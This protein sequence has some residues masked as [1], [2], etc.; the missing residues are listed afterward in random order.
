MVVYTIILYLDLKII[1][2]KPEKFDDKERKVVEFELVAP[3]VI[4][5]A[6]EA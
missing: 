5:K 2:S 4:R 1:Q 6:N 3:E